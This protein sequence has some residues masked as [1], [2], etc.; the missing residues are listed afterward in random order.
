MDKNLFFKIIQAKIEILFL[1]LNKFMDLNRG[2][3]WI[4]SI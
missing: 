1:A 2:S 3:A 4:I